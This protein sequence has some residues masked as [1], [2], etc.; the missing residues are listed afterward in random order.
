MKLAAEKT[1]VVAPHKLLKAEK[2][3][4]IEVS[5]DPDLAL[6]NA[7]IRA[8][9]PL[10]HPD[11]RKEFEAVITSVPTKEE[12]TIVWKLRRARKEVEE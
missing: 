4:E 8:L 3:V 1:P 12:K 10:M 7:A 11:S 2:Q 9:A 6:M 5:I